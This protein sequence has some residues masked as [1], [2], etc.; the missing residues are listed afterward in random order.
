VSASVIYLTPN[1]EK[2]RDQTAALAPPHTK[3]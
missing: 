1:A 3:D 2:R